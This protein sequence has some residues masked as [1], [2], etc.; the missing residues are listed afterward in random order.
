MECGEGFLQ[1]YKFWT[2]LVCRILLE[3]P[4][5]FFGRGAGAI[6]YGS[7]FPLDKELPVQAVGVA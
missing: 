3:F 4:E 6:C 7:S 5:E 1:F 2:D